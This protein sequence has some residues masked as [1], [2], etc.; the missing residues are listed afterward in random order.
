M[1]TSDTNPSISYRKNL[2][3][4][5]DYE[6]AIGDAWRKAAASIIEVGT[7][8]NLARKNLDRNEWRKLQNR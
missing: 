3:L 7:Q 4:V 2:S 6:M 8:L 1:N 5:D